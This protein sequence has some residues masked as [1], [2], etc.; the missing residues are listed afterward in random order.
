MIFASQFAF[1]SPTDAEL[2]FSVG[3]QPNNEHVVLQI[4]V[5]TRGEA[6][7]KKLGKG[8]KKIIL[9]HSPTLLDI[10]APRFP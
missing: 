3:F 9:S 4:L 2:L 10:D 1:N 5:S 7:K 8:K 6:Q